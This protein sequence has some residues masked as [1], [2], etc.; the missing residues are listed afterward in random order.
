MYK[1]YEHGGFVYSLDSLH[2]LGIDHIETMPLSPERVWNAIK[3]AKR[4]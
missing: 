3:N 4:S 2:R 1:S